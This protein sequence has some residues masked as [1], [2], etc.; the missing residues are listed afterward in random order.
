MTTSTGAPGAT[1]DEVLQAAG[2]LNLGERPPME[3]VEKTLQAV[4]AAMAGV[5][6]LRREALREGT[7]RALT[8]AGIRAPARMVDAA[9]PK[10][11]PTKAEDDSQGQ[12]LTLEDPEPWPEAVDGRS[13]LAELV[14]ILSRHLAIPGGGATAI[15]LWILHA[16][17]HES[18]AVSPLLAVTSP[19]KRCGKSTLLTLLGAL[20]PRPL[21]ASN[22]TPAALFRSVERWRPTL[23]VDEADAFLTEKE[24]LR[25]V[26]NSGHHRPGAF[27]VRTVGDDHEA[28]TFSTWAAKA[29]ALIGKLPATLMDRSIEIAMRRRGPGEEV[30]RVRLD[31]LGELEPLRRRAWTWARAHLAELRTP[32]PGIPSGLHD[33]AADNWR[34]ML[35]IADLVGEPWPERARRAA[36]IL[37]GASE[38]EEAATILLEDIRGIF[39]QEG[40]ERLTSFEVVQA[41]IRREDRPWPEWRRGQPLS[42]R[43]LARLLKPYG[44]HPKPMDWAGVHP[45]GTRGYRIENFAEA[46]E[47]YLP[48]QD[49]PSQAQ[50]PQP[51]HSPNVSAASP[52]RNRFPLVAD[53]APTENPSATTKVA[54]VAD[55]KEGGGQEAHQDHFD[56]LFAGLVP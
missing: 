45:K 5:D 36:L 11:A 27:V 28:K 25:G 37:S 42:V 23:L 48:A 50:P 29:V 56:D 6:A 32:D 20:V 3:A 35:A 15:A 26:L 40:R 41:L 8:E 52:L 21:P 51:S 17:T 14:H 13:L 34:H 9:L 7:I 22:I 30:E 47:R 2:L 46:W 39:Q 31:R 1:A 24:E 44:I 10:S 12:R 53:G 18:A 16:H 38:E 4:A 19:V 54:Q 33:R 49:P 55:R 43:G